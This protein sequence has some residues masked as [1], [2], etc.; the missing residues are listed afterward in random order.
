[1]NTM[2]ELISKCTNWSIERGIYSNGR[3]ETQALKLVSE[4]G[5]TC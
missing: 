2:S 3:I 4:V 5:E 1:M